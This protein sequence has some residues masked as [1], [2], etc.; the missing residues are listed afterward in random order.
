[1]IR[2]KPIARGK[3][4]K[5]RRDKPRRRPVEVTDKAYLA[6]VRTLPCAR[7]GLVGA[8]HAHHAGFRGLGQKCPDRQTIALDADCHRDWHDCTGLFAGWTRE[9]RAEWSRAAIEVTQAAYKIHSDR[10]IRSIPF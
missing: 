9:R 8:S 7:C 2:S 6:F 5:A 10:L 4:I 1:M 3:R